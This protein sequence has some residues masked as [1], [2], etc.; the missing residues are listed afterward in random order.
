[1]NK[2]VIIG[3]GGHGRVT[4]DTARLNGYED[5]V[6]L[7]D[8]DVPAAAGMVSDYM[9]YAA[10]ADF[11]VAI[12]NGAVRERIQTMLSDAG[13]R[14]TTLIHPNAVIGSGVTI[15]EGTVVMAGAVV[16][17]GAQIGCGVILNTCCSADH[18]CVIGDYCHISVGAHLAGSVT[19]GASTFICAGA[20]VINNTAVCGNCVIGAGAV[21]I[22]NID[23]PGTYA[24]VPAKKIK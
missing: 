2:L 12:G 9:K 13:C 6:F 18:D 14:I 22:R 24:G 3:A 23:A 8:G 1:M 10:E 7:D 17:T 11:I 21:V 4:A 16:N 15:G 19:V 20:T 5:I